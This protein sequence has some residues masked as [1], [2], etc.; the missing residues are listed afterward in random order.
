MITD[1][2]VECRQEGVQLF[3][4]HNPVPDTLP[5]RPEQNPQTQPTS[6]LLV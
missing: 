5:P 3:G 2:H 6:E 4:R 1:R